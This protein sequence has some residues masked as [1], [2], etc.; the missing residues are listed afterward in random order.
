MFAFILVFNVVAIAALCDINDLQ[1]PHGEA[2]C[3]IVKREMLDTSLVASPVYIDEHSTVNPLFDDQI[4]DSLEPD[5]EDAPAMYDNPAFEDEPS[6]APASP[7]SVDKY[8]VMNPVFESDAED[9]SGPAPRPSSS[10]YA[11][12]WRSLLDESLASL[13]STPARSACGSPC[14]SLAGSLASSRRSL[15]SAASSCRLNPLFHGGEDEEDG[16]EEEL[17]PR[18][19]F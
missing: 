4:E 8:L 12:A 19:L 16:E 14:S 9:L 5:F 17:T 7:L 13:P 1:A 11:P 6:A 18:C 2:D 3:K 15:L 10:P